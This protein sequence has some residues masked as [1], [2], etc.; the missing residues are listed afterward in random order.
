MN[1]KKNKTVLIPMFESLVKGVAHLCEGVVCPLLS[2][3]GVGGFKD[4]RVRGAS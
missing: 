1:H 4:H 2:D 3:V